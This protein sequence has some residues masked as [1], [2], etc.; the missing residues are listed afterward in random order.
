MI[1]RIRIKNFRSLADVDVRLSPA[2]V[3]IGRSG[4]GKSN[5]LR[6]IRFLRDFISGQPMA[7]INAFGGWGQIV[8]RVNPDATDVEFIAN[9]SLP[10]FAEEFCYHLA[11]GR[12]IQPGHLAVVK[13]TLKAGDRNLIAASIAK[14]AVPSLFGPG[15]PAPVELQSLS[16]NQEIAITFQVLSQGVGC[17]DFPG[18]VLRDKNRDKAKLPVGEGLSDDGSTYLAAL[19]DIQNDLH[20]LSHWRQ[21]ISA[22]QV[23]NPSFDSLGM[24]RPIPERV[25]VVHRISDGLLSFELAQESEGFR[26]FLAHVIALYQTPPKFLLAFEEP[27]KGIY[28]GALAVLAEEFKACAASGRGQ[29]ILTTHSPQLLDHFDPE[30]VRVVEITDMGTRIGPMSPEQ[31]ESVKE[32]LMTTGELLTVDPARLETPPVEA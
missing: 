20:R 16:G 28:P 29:V 31:L 2:T 19:N 10:G 22:A 6:A 11:I 25:D 7:V 3:L 17:Y 27:E 26:K 21:I 12:S 1:T 32:Q 5:F 8:S 24:S 9:F 30:Q 4:T 13:E 14:D 18:N 23:I 15:Q